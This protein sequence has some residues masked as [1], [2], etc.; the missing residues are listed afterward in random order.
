MTNRLRQRFYD[1]TG[2]PSL[3]RVRRK[4]VSWLGLVLLLFNVVAGGALPAQTATAD[5]DDH[6]IICTAGGLAAV[7]RNGT[8]VSA[9][10]TSENGFCA[11]CLPLCHGAILTPEAALVPVPFV[12]PLP[13][14]PLADAELVQVAPALRLGY[15][16]AP[17]QA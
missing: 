11:S 13:R 6:L 1:R 17:P 15:P 3:G 8:P 9:D 14:A 10:H 7:D 12:Q 5:A 16:R 4:F 2:N